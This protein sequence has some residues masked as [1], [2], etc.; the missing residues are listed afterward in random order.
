MIDVN[1]EIFTNVATSVRDK[2]TGCTVTG[3]YT[4][5]PSK[6]PAVTLDEIQNV[7]VERLEDSSNAENYAGVTYRLQVFSN[8]RTGKKN[9]A[10]EI[11]ATADA[12]MRRMGFRRV[13][14][15]VTPEIYDSTI[16]N[17]TA[18]YEAV[19]SAAGYVYKR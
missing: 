5:K 12:E 1:N 16:Y 8:K 17:I 2:H 11:F 15:T 6:F 9:E 13:T 7:V 4:R 10:R 19:V 18:T 3:E 14:Y